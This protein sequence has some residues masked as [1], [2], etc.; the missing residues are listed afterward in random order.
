MDK[1]RTHIGSKR[2]N[3]TLVDLS[4]PIFVTCSNEM[5]SIIFE[6]TENEPGILFGIS[7]GQVD[8]IFLEVSGID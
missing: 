7:D 2:R 3:V 4:F 8:N 1:I 5:L 6:R